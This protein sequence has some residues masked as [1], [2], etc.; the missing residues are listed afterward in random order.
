MKIGI[1]IH[2]CI[3]KYPEH[4]SFLTKS[5]IENGC[6]VHIITGSSWTEDIIKYLVGFNIFWSHHFS[7]TDY[8]LEKGEVVS[9]KDSDNPF[10]SDDIWNQA[11]AEYCEKNNI[12]MHFDD[13]DVYGKYFKTTKYIKII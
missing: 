9:W 2:N 6:E 3:D 8:L 5:L 12:D 1:D 10:F 13:S 11:K 4:F 7:I